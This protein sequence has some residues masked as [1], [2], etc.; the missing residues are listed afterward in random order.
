M[1]KFILIAAFVLASATAQAGA[2]RGLALA[3]GDQPAAAEQPKPAEAPKYVG[4]P[5][6]V[7]S[8]DQ[9][10]ADEVR[11]GP[12][13]NTRMQRAERPRRKRGLTLTRVVYELHRHGIY[14]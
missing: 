13:R 14:W 3:S 12:D 5:A 1:R 6:A 2:T 7:N 9:P 8:S 11:S 10:Q 4:R